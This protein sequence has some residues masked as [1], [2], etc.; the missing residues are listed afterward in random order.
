MKR[1]A[2]AVTVVLALAFL[3]T[4]AFAQAPAS[5][6]GY[7]VSLAAGYS[8]TTGAQ[9]NNGFFSSV[10]VPLYTFK[11]KWDVNIAG[12]GDYFSIATPST[13]VITA[14]PEGR[15]QFSSASFFNGKVFQPFGNVGFG[16][17]K[18]NCSATAAVCNGNS[19]AAVKLGGGLDLVGTPTL[20]YRLFEFDYIKSTIFPGG[21][22]KLSNFA[23]VTTG[24]KINF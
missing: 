23:Q 21:S 6:P 1:I 17:A 11:D 18:S 16:V 5:L 24:L 22:V 15:F 9:N 10:G 3:A 8:L 4:F 12:R 13:Y 2:S 14:G 7:Q 20:T 19:Y